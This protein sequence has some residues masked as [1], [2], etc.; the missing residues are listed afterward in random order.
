M[1]PVHAER[2]REAGAE[3]YQAQ[4]SKAGYENMFEVNFIKMKE[5]ALSEFYYPSRS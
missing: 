2:E 1:K 3:L 5:R 4:N